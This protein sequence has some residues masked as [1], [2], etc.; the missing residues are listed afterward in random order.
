MSGK[1]VTR[2][3]YMISINTLYACVICTLKKKAAKN[4]N[5]NVLTVI[6]SDQ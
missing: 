4:I 2:Q 6:I 5:V 3:N 1:L